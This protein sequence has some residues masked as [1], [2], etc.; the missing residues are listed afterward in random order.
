MLQPGQAERW[1]PGGSGDLRVWGDMDI[2]SFALQH[3]ERREGLHQAVA[4]LCDEAVSILE[5]F[6]GKGDKSVS[7]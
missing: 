4:T 2:F 6:L 1:G 7:V 5:C 3:F